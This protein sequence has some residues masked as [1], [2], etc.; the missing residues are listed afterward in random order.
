MSKTN[1]FLQGQ[2]IHNGDYPSA[3][4]YNTSNFD[5]IENP[6]VTGGAPNNPLTLKKFEMHQTQ[7][8]NNPFKTNDLSHDQTI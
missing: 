4:Q 5:T 3:T 6:M 1:K 8:A 2:L 7:K